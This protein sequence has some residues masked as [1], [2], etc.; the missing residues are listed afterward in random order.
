MLGSQVLI[1]TMSFDHL[2]EIENNRHQPI[3]NV[4]VRFP[5][6]VENLLQTCSMKAVIALNRRAVP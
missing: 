3:S 6:D 5:V 1:D 4:G 2:E